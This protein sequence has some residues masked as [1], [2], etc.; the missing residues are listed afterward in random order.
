MSEP[1]AR[2]LLALVCTLAFA[3]GVWLLLEADSTSEPPARLAPARVAERAREI[4]PEHMPPPFADRVIPKPDAM[5]HVPSKTAAFCA[6]KNWNRMEILVSPGDAGEFRVDLAAWNRSLTGTRAGIASWM[7]YCK[8]D[9]RTVRIVA[10]DS[11][12][13]LATYDPSSGLRTN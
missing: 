7:S 9:G 3:G 13:L 2:G 11:G 1:G 6:E 4:P 12:V 5:E 10:A 8:G